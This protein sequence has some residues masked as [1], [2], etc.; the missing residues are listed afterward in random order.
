MPFEKGHKINRLKIANKKF[1]RLKVIRY[2]R[3]KNHNTM[4]L[5]KCSC[6]KIKEIVGAS[7][8]D[9]NT[10][11]CGCLGQE[12]RIKSRKMHGMRDHPFYKIWCSMRYRC[13]NSKY[14]GYKNYGGRGIK[15][16][17]HWSVFLNF[18]KD[19]YQGYLEH[20]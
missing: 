3:I 11:S 12:N 8:V 5:C 20:V 19:M 7:L 6:G 4:W 14:S 2:T 13:N 10:K 1:G 18:K 16:C 17:K 15:V 9:G